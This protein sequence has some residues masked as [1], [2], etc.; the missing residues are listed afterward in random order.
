MDYDSYKTIHEKIK[1]ICNFIDSNNYLKIRE[2]VVLLKN[3]LSNLNLSN[4]SDSAYEIFETERQ[5]NLNNLSLILTSID[6]IYRYSENIYKELLTSLNNLEVN[7]SEEERQKIDNYLKILKEIN[8]SRIDLND[9]SLN[10]TINIE[11]IKLPN[12]LAMN[13]NNNTDIMEYNGNNY[14]VVKT[15]NGYQS[16]LNK[17]GRQNPDGCLDYSLKY[18]DEIFSNSDSNKIMSYQSIGS[19]DEQEILKIM[20]NEVINGRPCVIRVN[21]APKG[22]GYTRH[23]VAVTG[24]REG[25]DLDNLS[26]SDFLIMDPYDAS[27]KT[28][29]TNR[30]DVYAKNLLKTEE[31]VYWRNHGSNGYLCLIFNNP[32]TYLNNNSNLY[33]GSF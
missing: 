2:E 9:S 32:S 10:T 20:S 12:N 6:T 25:A 15:N 13:E 5:N 22:D 8:D 18:S 1:N 27:L 24:I 17:I 33:R 21:G 3:K 30:A 23:F 19:N 28:L 7:Y 4:W 14:V 31:D 26:Q 16:V 29:D 11:N